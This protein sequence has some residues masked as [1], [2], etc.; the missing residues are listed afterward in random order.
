MKG[1]PE[2]V[3]TC[4]VFGVGVGTSRGSPVWGLTAG[5]HHSPATTVRQVLV[6]CRSSTARFW[7]VD[8]CGRNTRTTRL[9]E[10]L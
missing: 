3:V 2:P 8:V 7:S 4:H 5:H 10:W 9:E 6:A 1:V